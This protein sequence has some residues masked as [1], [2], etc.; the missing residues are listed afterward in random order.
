MARMAANSWSCSE[1]L[2]VEGSGTVGT[3][4]LGIG[5]SRSELRLTTGGC[6]EWSL[7]VNYPVA[8]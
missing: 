5:V 6:L 1:G 8:R 7:P 2:S 4:H 3:G